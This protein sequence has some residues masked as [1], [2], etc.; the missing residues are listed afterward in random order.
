L[1][2]RPD[3]PTLLRAIAAFL[4][5]DVR[6]A[7]QDRGLGFRL[8]IAAHLLQ[9]TAGQLEG[10]DAF[11]SG[12]VA[13]LSELLGQPVVPDEPRREALL[14]LQGTLASRLRDADVDRAKALAVLTP[15]LQAQLAVTSPRF[16]CA[17]DIEGER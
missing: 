16:D 7:V 11:E 14:R 3:E 12:S 8:R 5:G 4:D 10:A 6:G 1:V 2:P 13:A 9:T 15:I 17:L